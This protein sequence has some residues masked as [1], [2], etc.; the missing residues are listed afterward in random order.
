MGLNSCEQK[1]P[2]PAPMAEAAGTTYDAT[3]YI[4]GMGGHVAQAK[5]KIDPANPQPFQISKLSR[6]KIGTGKEGDQQAKITHPVHDPRINSEDRNTMFWATY[7]VDPNT[8]SFHVGKHDLTTK[9]EI[10]SIDVPVPE[11][12]TKSG[13]GYCA[14]AQTKDHYLPIAMTHPGYIDVYNKA[15]LSLVRRVFLEGTAA[16][17]GAPYHFYHGVNSNDGKT[18]VLTVNESESDHG[19]FV[20]K[21]HVMALDMDA[22]VNGEVKVLKKVVIPGPTKGYI[23]FRMYFSPD[24]STI[25]MAAAD[26]VILMNA[27][28]L[29]VI[30]T[31]MMPEGKQVHDSIFTP[32]GKYL[33]ATSRSKQG[34]KSI[35]WMVKYC[36]LILR[37]KH[38]WV[39]LSQPV[40]PAIKKRM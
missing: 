16:D 28:S 29:E 6:V 26:R 2:A 15:D 32:D 7:K 8:N 33:I 40:W 34:I 12:V 31:E 25:S 4:A 23:G 30:H 3:M 1:K 38:G 39:R 13:S 17:I 14:S 11:T 5:V 9:K 27:G 10:Q 35:H 22:F 18:L 36:F 37:P 24:D 19:P 21:L 20:G